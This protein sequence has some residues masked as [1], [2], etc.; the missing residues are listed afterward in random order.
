MKIPLFL[1]HFKETHCS[2]NGTPK[3]RVLAGKKA[4]SQES[5]VS[6]D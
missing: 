6:V 3:R 5:G 1:V 4:R 2:H